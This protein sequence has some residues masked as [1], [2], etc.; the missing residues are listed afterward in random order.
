MKPVNKRHV[1]QLLRL[2]SILILDE[3][4]WSASY[5]N[6]LICRNPANVS[7]KLGNKTLP[8]ELWFEILSWVKV[9]SRSHE[10]T[11]IYA[12][13][14]GSVQD[15]AG[16][17]QLALIC[18]EVK[19]WRACGQL[20]SGTVIDVYEKYLNEPSYIPTEREVEEVPYYYDWSTR[21]LSPNMIKDNAECP[22][23]VTNNAEDNAMRIPISHLKFEIKFLFRSIEVQDMISFL[24]GGDCHLCDGSR[25]VDYYHRSNKEELETYC[26]TV[27]CHTR[28]QHDVFCPLC[29]G[30]HNADQSIELSCDRHGEPE[31]TDEEFDEWADERLR[32]LGYRH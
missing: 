4:L 28:C 13:G 6:D 26:G 8:T 12:V 21:S 5:L 9:R 31:L 19:E 11:P 15:S 18:N 3:T 2:G 22:F 32:E 29:M 17:E 25:W 14:T 10:Y 20:M 27:A 24:E 1:K 16:R 7:T 23:V 30:R